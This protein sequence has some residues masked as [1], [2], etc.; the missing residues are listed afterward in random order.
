MPGV[1][2]V[3]L[4]SGGFLVIDKTEALTVIDINKSLP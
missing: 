1:C 2:E 3:E 4:K